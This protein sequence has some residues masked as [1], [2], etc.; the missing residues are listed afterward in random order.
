MKINPQIE[1]AAGLLDQLFHY[2]QKLQQTGSQVNLQEL[3]QIVNHLDERGRILQMT[4]E[5]MA[6]YGPLKESLAKGKQTPSELAFLQEKRNR[7]KDLAPKLNQQEKQILALLKKEL[8]QTR[9]E[10][11]DQNQS[12]NAIRQ[13]LAAPQSKP[14]V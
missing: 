9:S 12:A 8:I 4:R 11:L 7:I 3:D 10:M 14:L 1:E 6:K 5:I 2:Y 13:Y